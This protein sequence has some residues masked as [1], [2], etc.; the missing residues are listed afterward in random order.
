MLLNICHNRHALRHGHQQKQHSSIKS[1]SVLMGARA[2]IAIN[3]KFV[4]L[5]S[6]KKILKNTLDL[7]PTQ[8]ASHNQDWY[9]F[10]IVNPHKPLFAILWIRILGGRK[11]FETHPINFLS[12][13]AS[14]KSKKNTPPSISHT[15]KPLMHQSV[16]NN[17]LCKL[18]VLWFSI[19]TA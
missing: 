2:W 10:S 1:S 17:L 14:E 5:R 4:L 12:N 3:C 6:E 11:M 16:P 8:D 19:P 15:K 9:I 7:P 13:T 18:S